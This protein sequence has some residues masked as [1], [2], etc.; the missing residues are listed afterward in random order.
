MKLFNLSIKLDQHWTTINELLK[1]D[2]I[3]YHD[4]NHHEGS[5]KQKYMRQMQTIE[6]C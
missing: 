2:Y 4:L 5:G 1:C 6:D 3:H